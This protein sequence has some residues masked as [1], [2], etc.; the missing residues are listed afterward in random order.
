[1]SGGGIG[2]I[3]IGVGLIAVARPFASRTVDYMNRGHRPP[4]GPQ[5][6]RTI[7]WTNR[8]CG[9]FAVGLGAFTWINP[10]LL[11]R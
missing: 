5:M 10:N 1:M 6:L 8:L 9:A 2:L 11:R 3:V 7:T 4:F